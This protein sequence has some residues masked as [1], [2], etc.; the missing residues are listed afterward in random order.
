MIDDPSAANVGAVVSVRGSVVGVRFDGRLSSIY[1]VLRTGESLVNEPASR[2]PAMQSANKNNDDLLE[3]LNGSFRRLRQSRS[4]EEL[5]DVISG[6]E[7]PSELS[8]S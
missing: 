4:N 2:L 7:A 3:E 6:V 8:L 5:F 1:S